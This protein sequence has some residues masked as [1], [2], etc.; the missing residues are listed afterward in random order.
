MAQNIIQSPCVTALVLSEG[1]NSNMRLS[2][3]LWAEQLWAEQLRTW[4]NLDLLHLSLCNGSNSPRGN[5][6]QNVTV[7]TALSRTAP[8]NIELLSSRQRWWT[9]QRII[10]LV[11]GA[12]Y[13][14]QFIRDFIW[15]TL[16]LAMVGMVFVWIDPHPGSGHLPSVARSGEC[17]RWPEVEVW[18]PD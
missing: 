6:Q 4:Y 7:R 12:A 8:N 15:L 5:E 3:Q 17:Q 16:E 18:W 13:S 10:L 9:S 14:I 1:T 11:T 2:E